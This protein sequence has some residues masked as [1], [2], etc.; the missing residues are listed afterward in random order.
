MVICLCGVDVRSPSPMCMQQHRDR[1]RSP[2]T[3]STGTPG[4]RDF[5]RA[6]SLR[7]VNQSGVRRVQAAA[8]STRLSRRCFPAQAEQARFVDLLLVIGLTSF[9]SE[10]LGP[11]IVSG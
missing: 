5:R 3:M 1:N 6:S 10:V 8:L 9:A 7:I 2:T 11:I 4:G